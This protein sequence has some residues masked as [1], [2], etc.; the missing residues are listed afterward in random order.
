MRSFPLVGIPKIFAKIHGE[1]SIYVHA[2]FSEQRSLDFLSAESE[3]GSK[4]SFAVDYAMAWYHP[5]TGI[6][7]QRVPDGARRFGRA[8][9]PRDL[10]VG[11]DFAF[12][13]WITTL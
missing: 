12:G 5:G 7:M 9:Y 3:S 6:E 8:Q 1:V 4:S 10:S 13:M 11:R 2:F